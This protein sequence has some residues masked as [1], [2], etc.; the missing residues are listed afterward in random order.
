MKGIHVKKFIIYCLFL[1][2]AAAS[3]SIRIQAQE[4]NKDSDENIKPPDGEEW[5]E[6]GDKELYKLKLNCITPKTG[7]TGGVFIY[8]GIYIKPPY[9]LKIVND[10]LLINNLPYYGP[11]DFRKKGYERWMA[12]INAI[13][14]SDEQE[15]YI[16]RLE[17]VIADIEN[18]YDSII[19]KY[20]NDY[21]EKLGDVMNELDSFLKN[22]TQVDSYK[23]SP[24]ILVEFKIKNSL[25]RNMYHLL[26][27]KTLRTIRD[28]RIDPPARE[29]DKRYLESLLK[30]T[31]VEKYQAEL[32]PFSS[33]D[34]YLKAAKVIQS[35]L[36]D[37][38]K[39]KK[40]YVLLN[41]L[42][43]AKLVF[44]NFNYEEF[45]TDFDR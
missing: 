15:E 3:A 10:T 25:D 11:L 24:G 33:I 8:F 5:I 13:K 20:K 38:E 7:I 21:D 19:A 12:R 42:D 23:I 22:H 45:L 41:D 32:N 26:L 39:I 17:K 40:L 31:F 18:K 29:S 6:L 44:Y 37:I 35:N 43:K 27:R 9:E 2:L 28:P 1:V 34:I 16:S 4:N 14:L 36:S 30:D